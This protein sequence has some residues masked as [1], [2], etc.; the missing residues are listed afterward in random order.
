MLMQKNWGQF[1]GEAMLENYRVDEFHKNG[2]LLG[3]KVLTDDEVKKLQDEL[4]RI[5][6]L[7]DELKDPR[8]VRVVNPS[9]G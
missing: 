8:P 3:D 5:I 9:S 7:Q 1:E 4:D 2:F 6:T